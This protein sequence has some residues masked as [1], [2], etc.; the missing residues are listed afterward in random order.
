M[1]SQTK[2][3]GTKLVLIFRAKEYK[4][5]LISKSAYRSRTGFRTVFKMDPC[6]SHDVGGRK[7][8]EN[9]PISIAFRP[10]TSWDKQGSILNTV[11]NPVRERVSGRSKGT[12]SGRKWSLLDD[13]RFP[14]LRR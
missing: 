13:S 6:L 3:V 12:G 9:G 5:C 1:P 10:P 7:A 11:R 8:I 2:V 4:P 14:T